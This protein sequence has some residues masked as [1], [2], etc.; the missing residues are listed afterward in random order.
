MAIIY[1]YPTLK[2]ELGDKVLGSNIVDSAGGAVQGNP[3]VQFTL[4]DIK[5]IV[6]QNFVQ[7]LYSASSISITLSESNDGS[8]IKFSATDVND[9]T[10]ANVYYTALTNQFTFRSQG[11]YYI[12]QE[13][14]TSAAGGRS[15]YFAFIT[16][17]AGVQV[18][19]TT[20]NKVWRQV[21]SD[22]LM[23]KISQI[24][25]VVATNEVY[26]FWGKTGSSSANENGGLIVN[27]LP[28][29]TD[30][31]SAGVKISKLI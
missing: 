6:A 15:P 3:T 5:T 9:S 28:S 18:G 30:V 2:P 14:N 20:V 12:E 17:K 1:S 23:V 8:S 7:Q 27:T 26:E 10:V 24:I 21:A 13:Y 22:R 25:Q 16:K 19:P 29:W 4:T 31:P 11:T